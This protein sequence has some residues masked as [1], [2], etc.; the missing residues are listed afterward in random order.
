MIS[1]A[2]DITGFIKGVP[3]LTA[4]TY[5]AL[6]GLFVPTFHKL[7]T[8]G[9]KSAD[10]SHGPLVLM[11]F[12]WL[13]WKKRDVL[14]VAADDDF[15]VVPLILLLF[16][17]ACYG[18]GSIHGSMMVES[19]SI[20]PIFLGTTGFLLGAK[21]ARSVLFP[22]LFL[23][24]LVPPPVVFTDMLTS[25]LKMLVATASSRLLEMAGYL[26]SRNGATILINDYSIVVGDPCSG[27][28]SL[29][30]LMAVG[31]LYAYLQDSSNLKKTVLF[32]SI[33]PISIIANIVRLIMLAL[34]T[35]YMGEAAAEGFLHGF[36]GFLLFVIA[37]VCLVVLDALM[38]RRAKHGH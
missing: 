19:F 38:E 27:L 6:G 15:R 20:I 5:L 7:S 22:S 4:V 18:A 10:Y 36:S 13:M 2:R 21:A 29:I 16:G 26:V 30:S 33:I 3:P 14:Q 28:R 9:W 12:F 32:L 17:L 23:S 37:M 1:G 8:Y 35:L 31:A 34:I 25:P 24:F 11:A